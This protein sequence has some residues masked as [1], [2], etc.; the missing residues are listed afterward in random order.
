MTE[1]GLPFTIRKPEV[2][3]DFPAS[4]PA[5]LVA[6]FLAEKKATAIQLVSPQEVI[7]A[8]DTVV[9]LENRILNKPAHREEAFGM[10]QQLQGKT[11]TVMTGVCL[12]SAA[13]K[14]VFAEKT[15]VTFYPLSPADI[16]RYIDLHRPYDKAGAYGAQDCLPMGMNPCS[17]EE[18]NFLA[19]VKCEHLIPAVATAP[20]VAII[21]KI[22]GSYFNVMGLPI[23]R[24]YNELVQI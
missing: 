15:L 19:E 18:L 3:E 20:P 7:I 6:S 1:L 8:A 13:N 14:V 23:H 10:L 24:T 17:A 9:I 21:S 12:L 2:E 5:T 11:H 16:Y 4:L 22:D